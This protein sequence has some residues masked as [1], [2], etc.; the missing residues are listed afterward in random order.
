MNV[1]E[2]VK[3]VTTPLLTSRCQFLAM[4]RKRRE[5]LPVDIK[6]VFVELSRVY[7]ERKADLWMYFDK[8]GS[9]I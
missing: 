1:A 8:I 6:K 7:A 9:I 4:N 5:S 3:Y 2:D